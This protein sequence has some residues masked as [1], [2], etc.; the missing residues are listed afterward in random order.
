[1]IVIEGWN[2]NLGIGKEW[3]FEVDLKLVCIGLKLVFSRQSERLLGIVV[4]TW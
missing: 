1:M 2:G 4:G 3:M